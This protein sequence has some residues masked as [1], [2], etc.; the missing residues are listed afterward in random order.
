MK[1]AIYGIGRMGRVIG[2]AMDQLGFELYA[3]DTR[4]ESID[5]LHD[6]LGNDT[7]FSLDPS[8][9]LLDNVKPDI[10][11]SSLPYHQTEKLAYHCI[12]NGLRYCDLGG[13][14]D[15]S[16]SINEY[17]EENA[18]KPVFTDLG[19]APGWVNILAEQGY[20]RVYDATDVKMMVGGIPLIRPVGPLKYFM[21]WSMDGLLNEYKDSC[22]VLTDGEIVTVP[23]LSQYETVD[24]EWEGCVCLEAFCTSGGAAH[25]T[26]R[27]KDRG[28]KNCVYKT[29]RWMGHHEL[30]DFFMNKCNMTDSE[31]K[32]ILETSAQCERSRD[33]VVVVMVEVKNDSGLIWKKEHVIE[34]DSKFSAM[35]KCT[36]FPI[37]TVASMMAEGVF[38]DR[39]DERRGYYIDLGNNLGYS[40]VPFDVFTKKL[41]TLLNK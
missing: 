35:Q 26:Q 1:A 41:D 37:S 33:D 6:L 13:R 20:K 10:V 27:M 23:G 14:V 19:L 8:F 18:T 29:L 40:D 39:K 21:T 25:T 12:D 4:M 11:I 17:A 9:D 15:V 7:D 32:H 38:D 24:P 31:L 28:V 2:Y 3:V 34:C 22:E 30:I 5:A 16:N 36:A